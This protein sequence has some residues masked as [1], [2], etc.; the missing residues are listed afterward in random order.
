MVPCHSPQTHFASTQTSNSGKK[1]NDDDDNDNY[2]DDD[3]DGDHHCDDDSV[4]HFDTSSSHGGILLDFNIL[5]Q[6]GSKR[7]I[8]NIVI[9]SSFL[10]LQPRTQRLLLGALQLHQRREKLPGDKNNHEIWLKN[11]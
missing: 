8:Y 3:G 11:I 10:V 6:I 9:S 2:D 4:T 5:S 7:I 1:M